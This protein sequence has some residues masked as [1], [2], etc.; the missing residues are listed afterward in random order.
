ML[1]SEPNN[2]LLNLESLSIQDA[3]SYTMAIFETEILNVPTST[4]KIGLHNTHDGLEYVIYDNY[5]SHAFFCSRD[6][7]MYPDDKSVFDVTR[8][9][10]IRW[11]VPVVSKL[12]NGVECWGSPRAGILK[13]A[14][15][16]WDQ[17]YIVWLR[18]RDGGRFSFRT[19]Y[20]C[21]IAQLRNYVRGCR[22]I[23]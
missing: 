6:R 22:R 19:A 3:Q 4:G 8:A 20:C 9:A 13:R 5:F 2:F 11:I 7:S 10:R 12:F 15:I 17:K 1:N 23:P 18:G 16:F 21:P 14:Y